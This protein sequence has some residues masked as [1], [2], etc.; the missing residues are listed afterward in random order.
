MQV[1][2]SSPAKRLYV[3]RNNK[4]SAPLKG[5]LQDHQILRPSAH[6]N[7]TFSILNTSTPSRSEL[8]LSRILKSHNDS[9]L[10]YLSKDK[11]NHNPIILPESPPSS[12]TLNE[13]LTKFKLP[14]KPLL[15]IENQAINAKSLKARNT[16]HQKSQGRRYPSN[17]QVTKI[18]ANDLAR[19]VGL[20]V[21][22]NNWQWWHSVAHCIIGNKS[23]DFQ[24]FM[25]G[26]KHGNAA[27]ADLAEHCVGKLVSSYPNQTFYL[28]V[29]AELIKGYE[30][31]HLAESVTWTLKNDKADPSQY[32]TFTFHPL[33]R[34]Q[35]CEN[36]IQLC[37][38]LFFQAF[39]LENQLKNQLTPT[40]PKSRLTDSLTAPN[41]NQCKQALIFSTP[42]KNSNPPSAEKLSH[43]KRK[44]SLCF[45][46]PVSKKF[47][48][49][50]TTPLR[51][52]KTIKRNK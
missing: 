15:T 10:I 9:I 28:D 44:A 38:T 6:P 32:F 36:E 40:Q 16:V 21:T 5:V 27:M 14:N 12:A 7:K 30:K 19:K 41:F 52:Y 46:T 24:Y 35:Q 45:G 29:K 4:N 2:N 49:P 1:I 39:A 11:V 26:N 37:R 13:I 50:I 23:Q 51:S 31:L 43:G 47:K 20:P 22:E 34:R 3:L 17:Q 18:T 48:A 42:Q 8:K 25:L 33:E